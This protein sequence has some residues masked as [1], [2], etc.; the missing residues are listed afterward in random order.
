MIRELYG[1]SG[2]SVYEIALAEWHYQNNRCFDALVLVTETI[3]LIEYEDDMRC[4]FVAMALQMRILLVN[5]Q[6]E[7]IRERIH[8]TGWEELTSSLNALECLAACYDGRTDEVEA[9]LERVAPDENKSIY[10]MDMYAYLIKVRCYLQMGK[11]MM[12]Q[13]MS[14]DEI[15]GKPGKKAGTIKFHSHNIF[16]KLQVQNRQQAVNRARENGLL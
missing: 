11:Y 15:A 3:P 2:K 6:T 9:W 14:D 13:G 10:M 7:K 1:N 8:K 4:L 5:G 16:R 12:A